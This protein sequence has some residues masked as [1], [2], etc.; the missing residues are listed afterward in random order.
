MAAAQELQVQKKREVENKEETTIPARS[1]VPA[2]DIYEGE[3]SLMV[4]L[5]MPVWKRRT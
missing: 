1:F 2:A 4:I 3:R 5:E